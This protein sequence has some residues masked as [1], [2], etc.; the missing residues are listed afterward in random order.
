LIREARRHKAD[1]YICHNLGALPATVNAA[2]VNNKPCGFDAEDLHRYEE[3]DNDDDSGV[4]LKTYIESKYIPQVSYLTA[5]SPGINDAY[6]QL[7]KDKT[8]VT[9]LNVF[10][11][12]Y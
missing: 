10:P 8:P 7:Y 3:S 1:L 9:L 6:R 11:V 5:S 12:D 4:I 2:K